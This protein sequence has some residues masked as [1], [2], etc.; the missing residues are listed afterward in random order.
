MRCIID[1]LCKDFCFVC[2]GFLL[3]KTSTCISVV[4]YRAHRTTAVTSISKTFQA[5]SFISFY[6]VFHIR[7]S[8]VIISPPGFPHIVPSLSFSTM[9]VSLL[10]YT[11]S[12]FRIGVFL[13]LRLST[14]VA[15]GHQLRAPLSLGLTGSPGKAVDCA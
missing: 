1:G 5:A 6:L 10:P 14:S 15:K 11:S 3:F 2:I 9:F 13:L 4:T 8:L 12:F 7:V